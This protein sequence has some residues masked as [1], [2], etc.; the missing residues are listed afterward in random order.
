M[1][2][3]EMFCSTG[4]RKNVI[5]SRWPFNYLRQIIVFIATCLVLKA[6]M[7]QLQRLESKK[8]KHEE[9][10]FFSTCN[11]KHS[12]VKSD[13]IQK[14]ATYSPTLKQAIDVVPTDLWSIIGELTAP[15]SINNHQV[16][17]LTYSP[18]VYWFLNVEC[19]SNQII[20]I[21]IRLYYIQFALFS[22]QNT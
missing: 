12:L 22:W 19:V 21:Q 10:F 16:C 15:R 3:Y 1:P 13:I 18:S 2:Y 7:F 14:Q 11:N 17:E 5:T 9:C 20:T 6:V 4:S 8:R